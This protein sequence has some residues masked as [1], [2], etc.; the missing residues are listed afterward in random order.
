MEGIYI[1]TLQ[2]LAELVHE[3]LPELPQENIIAE[4]M[5]R[6]TAPCIGLSAIILEQVDPQGVMAVFPA[7]SVIKEVER[8][9]QLLEVAIDVAKRGEHIVTLGAV[10]DYPATGYG[11]I[12]CGELFEGRGDIEVHRVNA[13]IEK[14]C[15]DKARELF[16]A[17]AYL[18]NT[19]IYIARVDRV[20]TETK[21]H[22][23]ALYADLMEIKRGLGGPGQGQAIGEAYNRW[24]ENTSFER[25]ILEQGA[26]VLVIPADVGWNDVGS[27]AALDSVFERGE[28]GNIIQ[29]KHM[30]MDTKGSVIF[31]SDDHK[32]IATIGLENIVIVETGDYLLVMDKKR[33][34]DVRKIAKRMEKGKKAT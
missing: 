25:R 6:G 4:P 17:K 28:N 12:H 30:G 16:E 20:L 27:W 31:S 26:E 10:P 2:E 3:Q 1:V 19:S 14:P 33:A 11:Y 23:P 8:Y 21:A 24:E 9:L 34:Q 32:M 22:L 7:D 13:F 18:W 15:E 29:A 5:G